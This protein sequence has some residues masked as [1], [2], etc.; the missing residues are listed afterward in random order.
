V[1]A[2]FLKAGRTKVLSLTGALVALI[3]LAD[4]FVGNKASLGVFYILPMMLGAIVL[5]PLEIVALAL[6]CSFLKSWF[7]IPSPRVEVL[8]RFVFAFLAYTGSGFFVIALMR[9]RREQD[10]RR[11]AEEQLKVLVESSP[12]AIL[13]LDGQGVV[14][15]AN[16]AADKMF[17]IEEG[18]TLR[19]HAI[20]GYLPVLA[21]ALQLGSG[22]AGLRTAAQCQA[23]R[24]NGEMFL[25]HTWFSSYVEA[26]GIRLA[27][28]VVDSSEEMRDREE[29]GLRQLIRGNR[30]AAAA[31]S[32]EVRNLCSAISLMCSGLNEKHG[33][34]QDENFQG[35]TTLVKG[36]ER[37][38]SV[39][40]QS[41]VHEALEKVG[42]QQVLNDLRIVIEP[43]WREIDGIVNWRLPAQVPTVLAERHGLLQAFL[44]LAQNS[45][46]A[47]QGCSVRELSIIVSVEQQKVAIRFLDTGPGI[48]APERLFEPFQ[49]G[50]DGAGLG[51]YVARAVLRSYGGELRYEPQASGSCF[52]V[53]A[54]VF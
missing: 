47:V 12:A 33:I 28:I 40:L 52:V 2:T 18:Q 30:I 21:D 29:Q 32:H 16:H 43:D 31:V 45:L 5:A 51:L 10:L 9:N 14:L 46:R 1:I 25:A 3:A 44:N 50:A 41:R 39:E 7:D 36:L 6:V 53:E 23:R 42:L 49:P 27:A 37:I 34:A 38:A 15:A 20:G 22:A 26:D 13:T 4:W 17:S 48:P 19:G 8:L 24:Q 54:Q 35:L 11:E